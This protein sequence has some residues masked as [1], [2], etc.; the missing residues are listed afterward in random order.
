VICSLTGRRTA[1][2]AELPDGIR[3]I[4]V[5]FE[6]AVEEHPAKLHH[7]QALKGPSLI[8]RMA[9]PELGA[10]VALR[11]RPRV[12]GPWLLRIHQSDYQ[13]DH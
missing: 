2:S 1:S 10:P 12:H 8:A 7:E 6:D 13:K 4:R 3:L 5:S 9:E 11:Q